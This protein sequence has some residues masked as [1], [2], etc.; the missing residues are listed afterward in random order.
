M[1]ITKAATTS[2]RGDSSGGITYRS[3]PT[4][5]KARSYAYDKIKYVK[6]RTYYSKNKIRVWY[7]YFII[8]THKSST[9][10][11]NKNVLCF[12]AVQVS[13]FQFLATGQSQK[14]QLALCQRVSVDLIS[15]QVYPSCRVSLS[16][17]SVRL[18]VRVK[19]S[20]IGVNSALYRTNGD[21][22]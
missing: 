6:I 9:P 15:E 5:V 11:E 3:K 2:L 19:L 17:Y 10:A 4:L 14:Q 7:A 16:E 18:Q 12:G 8:Y 13:T 22:V 20:G 1:K 21:A